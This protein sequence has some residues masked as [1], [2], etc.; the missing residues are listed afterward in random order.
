[1]TKPLGIIKNLKIHM[2]GI[3]YVAIFIVLQNNAIDSNYSMLL[4]RPWLRYAKVTHD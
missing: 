1:M 3:Q 4:G 2:H